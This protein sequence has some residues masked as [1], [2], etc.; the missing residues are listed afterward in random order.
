MKRLAGTRK[1]ALA[2][3]LLSV[4]LQARAEDPKVKAGGVT[5]TLP[6]PTSDMVEVGDKLRTTFF[7]LLT[8]ANNR[9]LAAYLPTQ[10]LADINAAKAERGADYYA[11][12]EVSRQ[13]EYAEIT[14]DIFEDIRKEMESTLGKVVANT[15]DMG[16]GC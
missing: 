6:G 13:A 15:D 10:R 3:V 9:L 4:C 8:P 11:L 1:L 16:M 14:P 12:V 2:I 5:L 7:E